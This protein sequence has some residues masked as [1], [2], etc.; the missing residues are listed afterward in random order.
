MSKYTTYQ[1]IYIRFT[2]KLPIL[3]TSSTSFKLN[4]GPETV[5]NENGKKVENDPSYILNIYNPISFHNYGTLYII[6][7]FTAKS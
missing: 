4:Q 1:I 7:C 5:F 2:K 6:P 3:H